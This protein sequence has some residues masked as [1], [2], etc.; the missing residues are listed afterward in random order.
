MSLLTLKR[1][2]LSERDRE[3][4]EDALLTSFPECESVVWHLDDVELGKLY[5]EKMQIKA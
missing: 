3:K 2:V 1:Y 4:L 5:H